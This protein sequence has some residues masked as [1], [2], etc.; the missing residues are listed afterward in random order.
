MRH[1][2]RGFSLTRAHDQCWCVYDYE[3]KLNQFNNT[4][5][6]RASQFNAL[7]V[8]SETVAYRYRKEETLSCSDGRLAP[9]PLTKPLKDFMILSTFSWH[10][11]LGTSTTLVV[12]PALDQEDP[13]PS[14]STRTL[15]EFRFRR[16]T[17]SERPSFTKKTQLPSR[18]CE[19]GFCRG[20]GLCNLTRPSFTSRFCDC[21]DSPFPCTHSTAFMF[22]SMPL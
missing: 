3:G 20:S 9:K 17:L 2:R 11:I 22:H 14:N 16:G 6:T 19:F 21:C 1:K 18:H 7:K 15:C 5:H 10:E 12:P 4:F 13:V 8:L